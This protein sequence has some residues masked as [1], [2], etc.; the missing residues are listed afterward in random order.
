MSKIRAAV[1]NPTREGVGSSSPSLLHETQLELL[2]SAGGRIP[3]I[4][5]PLSLDDYTGMTIPA[6]SSSLKYSFAADE[7]T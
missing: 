3:D 2:V 4:G 1:A 5:T 6:A 7:V